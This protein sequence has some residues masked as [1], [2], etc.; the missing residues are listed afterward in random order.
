MG[1][2][3]AQGLGA[4]YAG[5]GIYN[6]ETAVAN[7]INMDTAMRYNEYLYESQ[8]ESTRRYHQVRNAQFAKDNAAYDAHIKHLQDDPSDAEIRNGDALNT[9]LDQLGDPRI[10]SSALR[11]ATDPVDAQLIRDIPFRNASEAITITLS[12]FKDVEKWPASLRR[13]RFADDHREFV[14]LIEQARKQDE[15]GDVSPETLDKIRG[16]ISRV[17]GKLQAQ[18]L[19]DRE[20]KEAL[21]FLKGLTALTRLVEMPD[22]KAVLDELRNMKSTS[23]GNLMAFMH[24]FNL[25]FGEPQTPKQ[26]LIYEKLYPLMDNARD[27]ILGELKPAPSSKRGEGGPQVHDFF[28]GVDEKHLD[29][30]RGTTPTPPAPNAPANPAPNDNQ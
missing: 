20:Q 5:A 21:N 1:G 2:N 4:L 17:R 24:T 26:R 13:E 15:T 30:K 22:V 16:V 23:I 18:P 9:A 14:Q 8:L 19:G 28:S 27:R 6:Q 10:H 11:L 29:R 3:I 7:S 25:R 12:Q